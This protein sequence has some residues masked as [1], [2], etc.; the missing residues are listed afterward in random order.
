MKKIMTL[1][2]L[3]KILCLTACC[4]EIKDSVEIS[5]SHITSHDTHWLKITITNNSNTYFYLPILSISD[6]LAESIQIFD[7][8]GKSIPF[9]MQPHYFPPGDDRL[10]ENCN[11]GLGISFLDELDYPPLNQRKKV[12]TRIIQNEYY[13]LISSLACP[14]LT[15][16]DI[17]FLKTKLLYKYKPAIFLKPGDTYD[18][19]V[20]INH[21][22]QNNQSIYAIIELVT[23]FEKEP[24]KFAFEFCPDS[25]TITYEY[26][27]NVFEYELYK[28]KLT[29]DTV[30][31]SN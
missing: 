30:F 23:E 10:V 14:D 21:I 7:L 27:Q 2:F 12:L 26:P 28:S 22:L 9:E 19:C 15:T 6:N 4:K 24:S 25:I 31:I 13:E 17:Y 20:F 18:E 11:E 3:V 5:L 29:S 1:F 8:K 16:D